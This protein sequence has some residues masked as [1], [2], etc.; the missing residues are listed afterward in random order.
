MKIKTLRQSSSLLHL[1]WVFPLLLF[2]PAIFR[3]QALIWG[4][5]SLQFIPWRILAWEQIQAGI[6]PFWNPLNGMGAPLL[7]NYQLAFFYPPGWPLYALQLLGGSAWLAWGH[8]LLLVAHLVWAGFGTARLVR[9]LGLGELP[10]VVAGLAFSLSAYLVARAGFFSMVWSAA[11]LPWILVCVD[12][13]AA[14]GLPAKRWQAV[15]WLGLCVGMQL[16]SGH[17]QLTW[18]S[19]IF[20]GG[21]TLVAGY[22]AGRWTRMAVTAGYALVGVLAG[23]ALAAVQ[24]IPTFELLM[25]SQRA[26]AVDFDFAMTYSFWPWRLL[27]FLAPSFF[28]N[29][30]YGDYWGYASYWEDAVYI[31]LLP[32]F[33]A[34]TSLKW[35]RSGKSADQFQRGL[36]AKVRF[37]WLAALAG[38]LLALGKNTPIFPFLYRNVPTF[39]MFQAP[40]RYMLWPVFSLSVL[41]A[42]GLEKWK[43]PTG[44]AMRRLRRVPVIL[45]AVAIGAGMAILFVPGIKISF[46]YSVFGW[47]LLALFFVGLLQRQP[48]DTEVRTHEKWTWAV[49]ILVGFDLL[50]AGW[51]QN[52][53]TAASFF[54][55]TA[56]PGEPIQVESAGR[57]FVDEETERRL[58][59]DRFLRFEDYRPV[60][61]WIG[62]RAAQLP[63]LNIL[64]GKASANNF[65]PLRPARYDRWM[66]YI[67]SLQPEAR[68]PWLKM[69]N[70]TEIES[71]LPDESQT[72]E[73]N[74]IEGGQRF[75]FISCA[76][77]ARDEM[78]AWEKT[79]QMVENGLDQIVIETDGVESLDCSLKSNDKINILSERADRL[80]ISIATDV[81]GWLSIADTWYPGWKASIDG[82]DVILYRANYAFRGIRIPAGNHT[83]VIHYQPDWWQPAVLVSMA[84]LLMLIIFLVLGRK[85]V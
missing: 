51:G 13:L 68:L 76:V 73:F 62:M 11:W 69:M 5:P 3:G 44:K 16:L 30:A 81:N 2:S 10:Q 25:Q 84:G 77:I 1:L 56:L 83:V 71:I 52:P 34:L 74:P 64:D 49:A 24:L 6:W 19:L 7:A 66:E 40:A 31:G 61:N 63:N 65:D 46:I 70:V 28:G 43:R 58:K 36:P 57:L 20:A 38:I 85:S 23:A 79:R 78:D 14:A 33:M 21:W 59:F 27:T 41:C 4:T 26:A 72:F 54:V 67:S 48:A 47:C 80:V 32:F 39:D 50:I 42:V 12:R 75:R 29:P 18:Y 35:I 9:R 55:T 22:S 53:A 37:L 45:A 15:G 8:T 82:M 17:A 60:E